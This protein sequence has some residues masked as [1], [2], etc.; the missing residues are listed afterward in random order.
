M[1]TCYEYDVVVYTATAGGTIAARVRAVV[2]HDLFKMNES[3]I[4]LA[5]CFFPFFISVVRDPSG[6][7]P[8]K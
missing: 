8:T 7:T 6:V 5:F 4:C 3:S 1:V 2:V